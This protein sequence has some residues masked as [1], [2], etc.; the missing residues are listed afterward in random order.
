[1][2]RGALVFMGI[3][4]VAITARMWETTGDPW[5]GKAGMLLFFVGGISG[6]L[7]TFDVLQM[8]G[9]RRG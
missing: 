2:I 6:V 7:I 1:M 4:A 5:F 3:A 8:M 9:K